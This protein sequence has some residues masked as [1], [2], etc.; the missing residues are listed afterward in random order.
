VAWSASFETIAFGEFQANLRA[1]E[2]RRNGVKVRVPDQSFHVLAMLLEHPGELITREEIRESLWPADTFVDFDHGLNNAVN[3]LRDAL[4]DSAES[5]RLIET[6]PRRGYRFIGAANA[7][8]S[9]AVAVQQGAAP[10]HDA[11]LPP[12]IR[13]RGRRISSYFVIVVAAAAILLAPVVTL[14]FRTNRGAPSVPIRSLAVLPLENLSGDSSQEYFADGMTD[15]LVT[16]LANIHSLRVVSR[17]SATHYKGSHLALPEIARNLQVD[18]LV[19]GSVVLSG[20]RVRVN[21]QLVQASSD[22][23]LWAKTYDREISEILDVQRDLTED[24]VQEIKAK[25]T[26]SEENKLASI[27]TVNPDAYQAYFKGRYQ[28][29]RRSLDGYNEGL[30]LFQQA[31]R[32][33]PTY[34]PAYAGIAHCYNYLALGM[35][36][37]PPRE[38]AR[39]AKAAARKAI[40]LD[41]TLADAHSALA[42]TLHHY[43]WDWG[44]AEKEAQRAREL[45]PKSEVHPKHQQLRD[46]DYP[47]SPLAVRAV[48]GSYIEARQLEKAIEYYKKAIESTPDNFRMRMDLAGDYLENGRYQEAAETYQGVLTQYGPNVYPLARLGYT[49]ARWGKKSEAEKILVQLKNER[50]Q[51][52]VSYAVAEIYELLGQHEEALS[53]LEKAY[54]ERA[55][56]MTEIRGAFPSLHADARYQGLV[57]RMHFPTS[58]SQ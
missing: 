34:A 3:R 37:I 43:D 10:T 48:A 9:G 29:N 33:D 57:E 46:S 54:E 24:I 45:N 17:T 50:R 41:E 30:A 31:I 32:L 26:P 51:G 56:Q 2:L 47:L 40:E 23:H 16:D 8:P 20:K 21:V 28:L 55:W 27:P 13:N 11:V 18:A 15:T 4:G 49:Y 35:G 36:A 22:G 53:W 58:S 12:E 38:A 44:E 1:R 19:Q 52:Y 14:K 25:L 42:F 39:R 5:P 6:L 7:L